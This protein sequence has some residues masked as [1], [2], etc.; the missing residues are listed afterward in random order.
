MP[1]IK[2][3]HGL[4][5]VMLVAA[6]LGLSI[7]TVASTYLILNYAIP[8]KEAVIPAQNPAPAPSVTQTTSIE[9]VKAANEESLLNMKGVE[10]VEVGEKEGLPCVIVFTY[11]ETDEL[12]KLENNGLNGYKVV[13]QNTAP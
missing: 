4:I 3:Q 5:P 2:N 13:I 12:D 7:V 10:K 1:N 9:E 8:T 11:E 6:L